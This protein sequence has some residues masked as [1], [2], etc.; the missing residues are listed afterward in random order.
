M[1]WRDRMWHVAVR[2]CTVRHAL[3]CAEAIPEAHWMTGL[4]PRAKRRK[5]RYRNRSNQNLNRSEDLTTAKNHRWFTSQKRIP[6][7][8]PLSSCSQRPRPRQSH[9]GLPRSLGAPRWPHCFTATVLRKYMVRKLQIQILFCGQK[10]CV[11]TAVSFWISMTCVLCTLRFVIACNMW[12][13]SANRWQVA[14]M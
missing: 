6:L 5:K 3:P 13:F 4:D 12:C 1:T 11:K 14:D 10:V 2:H 8:M 9:R 7:W